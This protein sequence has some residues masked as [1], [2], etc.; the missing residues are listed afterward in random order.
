MLSLD[1]AKRSFYLD[2]I[3]GVLPTMSLADLESIFF[4]NPDAY[5]KN[6]TWTE[7]D[8]NL[9]AMSYDPMMA[10]ASAPGIA[11]TLYLIRIKIRKS[12]SV[13]NILMNVNAAG[14]TLTVGQNF[15]GLWRADGTLIAITGDQSAN[16]QSTGLKTMSIGGPFNLVAGS[17]VYAGQWSNGATLPAFSRTT[18]ISSLDNVGLNAP[19][20]RTCTANVGLTTIPPD[21]IGAQVSSGTTQWAGLS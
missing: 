21:P 12:R 4:G 8:H 5:I 19:N 10:S 2:R 1:D 16:W 13:S 11:G 9:K 17:D 3:P 7:D 15:A 20:L 18:N 6:S 14:V